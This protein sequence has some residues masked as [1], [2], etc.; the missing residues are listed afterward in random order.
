MPVWY[1]VEP[2]LQLIAEQ[3]LLGSVSGGHRQCLDYVSDLEV[4]RI[5][6]SRPY[7]PV[8]A[9]LGDDHP[10]VQPPL[11]SED[12]SQPVQAVPERQS[13]EVVDDPHL[14]G[15]VWPTFGIAAAAA[16][17]VVARYLQHMNRLRVWA[18]GQL[19]MAVGVVIP[20]FWLSPTTIAMA[21][22]FVGG[23]FMVITMI[24]MQEAQSR[25]PQ[26]PTAL[27]G[28]MTAAFAV[29]QLAGPL[30]S[31]ILGMLPAGHAAGLNLALQTAAFVLASSA[32]YLFR[33]AHPTEGTPP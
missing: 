10:T 13:R 16:T 20:T 24:G 21:A 12:E 14:F 29:G 33:L 8:D 19:A 18:I 3:H 30:V 28:K 26:D 25:S 5:D 27:L 31:A 32:V 22:L 2:W 9:G 7:R 17:I 1:H 4:R 15:L 11:D 23:T 6:P